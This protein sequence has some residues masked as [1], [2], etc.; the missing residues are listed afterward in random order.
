MKFY[1]PVVFLLIS[2]NLKSQI[3]SAPQSDTSIKQK[4]LLFLKVRPTFQPIDT[5]FLSISTSTKE[6]SLALR[7]KVPSYWFR[8][9]TTLNDYFILKSKT[10]QYKFFNEVE[11][12]PQGDY[13][14][15]T[16][17]IQKNA[18][19]NLLKEK[20]SY[21]RFYFTPNNEIAI[22]IT[23]INQGKKLS[24]LDR[25]QIKVSKLS[26]KVKVTDFD[27]DKNFDILNWLNTF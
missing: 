21:L 15:F 18:L 8:F 25:H 7:F 11:T 24:E 13:Y 2:S 12:Y 10:N 3:E 9:K 26:F 16:S 27:L 23:E 5:V 17:H 20:I 22:K 4:N 14:M 1:L 19:R 6:D